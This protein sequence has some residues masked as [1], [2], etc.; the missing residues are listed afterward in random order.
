MMKPKERMA[1]PR[2]TWP[3]LDPE[4]RVQSYAEVAQ[5]FDEETVKKEAL[6]CLHCK[7]PGCR[8]GCPINNK[9][10]E[11]IGLAAEGKFED[12]Y[13]KIRETSSLPAVCSRVCPH[14][15]Q[16]EGGCVRGKKGNPVA[17]GMIERYIAD[18]MVKNN[19]NMRKS[20]ALK[21]GKKVAIVGSGPAGMTAAYHLAHAGIECTIYEALP[22]LGGMLK[23]GIP[24]Y[25]LPRYILDAEFM[26]LVNCGVK[27]AHGVV[28]GRD[29]S[30]ADLKEKEG[31]DAV[32]VGVGAH[33]SRKLGVDGEEMDGVL[34]GVDYLRRVLSGE[35]VDAGRNVVVVG[36][37]NVAIDCARVALREGSDKVFILYRRT[38]EEMPASGEEIHHLQQEGVKIEFLAA[39]VRVVGENGKM[40]GIECV[41]MQLGEPDDSGRC[42]P[43]VMEGSNYVI[44]ADS[45]IPAISQNVDHTVDKG[46][47]LELTSWGTYVVDKDTFQSNVDWL[48]SAGDSVLGPQTVAKAIYQAKEAAE[49]IRRYI[50]GEDM[51]AGRE[52]RH[53]D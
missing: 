49:S 40:T 23:V 48:F 14:E 33:N 9:I 32:F 50:V 27:I 1:I 34:H 3:E 24:P 46:Q 37:G 35:K 13:W 25:R 19:K 43:E 30:L 7:K 51:R 31:F 22:V 8:Q 16:C 6:R 44:P 10:P 53:L 17:I 20:C 42:R 47:D 21:T 52:V 26:A 5:G 29:M 4:V 41:K 15:F 28:I 36:G 18:W 38:I 2:Q 11:F 12:A 39:P 45:V